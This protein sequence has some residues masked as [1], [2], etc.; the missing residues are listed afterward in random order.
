MDK[1]ERIEKENIYRYINGKKKSPCDCYY[2]QKIFFAS[3]KLK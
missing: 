3:L 1:E 2:T